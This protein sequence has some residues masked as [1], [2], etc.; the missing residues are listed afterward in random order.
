MHL[1][2]TCAFRQRG[3]LKRIAP[4]S[5]IYEQCGAV[6]RFFFLLLYS[7]FSNLSRPHTQ[8]DSVCQSPFSSGTPGKQPNPGREPGRWDAG[9]QRVVGR[10]GVGVRSGQLSEAGGES[11]RNGGVLEGGTEGGNRRRP[12]GVR[13]D[14][15]GDKAAGQRAT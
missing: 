7:E 13:T 3:T 9:A 2:T 4:P 6:V 10:P 14:G 11:R 12:A 1:P 5:V 15:E 8:F